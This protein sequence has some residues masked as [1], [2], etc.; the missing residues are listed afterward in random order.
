MLLAKVELWPHN[1]PTLTTLQFAQQTTG[2]T[3]WS[4]IMDLMNSFK[5]RPLPALLG[6]A[7]WVS[8]FGRS[9]D[10]HRV[11]TR[12][13]VWTL[14]LGPLWEFPELYTWFFEVLDVFTMCC[15]A[16]RC[17]SCALNKLPRSRADLTTMLGDAVVGASA[18]RWTSRSSPSN[19]L[20]FQID[21][22]AP[23]PYSP[24]RYRKPNELPRFPNWAT[25]S[26]PGDACGLNV[27]FKLGWTI[28]NTWCYKYNS[29]IEVGWTEW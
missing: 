16:C 29:W 25:G 13:S 4:A 22:V 2:F 27:H 20:V 6:R 11:G 1:Y 15:S 18:M 9:S 26:D 8:G 24:G 3:W 12:R 7:A 23:V 5:L 19:F 17:W 21:G 28:W 14:W 10:N